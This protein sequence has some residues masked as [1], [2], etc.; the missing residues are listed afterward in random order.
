MLSDTR[1]SRPCQS[2]PLGDEPRLV[3]PATVEQ[4][5]ELVATDACERIGA[6][7][8]RAQDLGQGLEHAVAGGMTETVV[9]ELETVDV[10][11]EQAV[12]V[13]CAVLCAA[14]QL[15]QA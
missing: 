4:G 15:L 12:H 1:S 11:V 13:V 9:D 2:Q 8:T 6:A 10:D 14:Y 7:D 5:G 3:A